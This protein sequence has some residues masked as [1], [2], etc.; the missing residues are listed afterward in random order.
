MDNTGT[1]G[2]RTLS[3]E[4]VMPLLETNNFVI[5]KVMNFYSQNYKKKKSG[6][7]DGSICAASLTVEHCN[8]LS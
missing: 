4:T 7:N 2:N 8:Q 5:E 3:I 1:D 6:F